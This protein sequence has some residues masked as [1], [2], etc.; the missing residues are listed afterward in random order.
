MHRIGVVALAVCCFAFM[1]TQAMAREYLK[2]DAAQTRGF[3]LGTVTEGGKIVWLAG[4][5]A[6][7]DE[8]G[9]SLL[10]DTAGQAR[11]IFRAMQRTLKRA[12]ADLKDLTVITVYLTDPRDL[13]SLIPVRREFF[14]DGNFPAST[15]IT[16][17][18][19]PQPGMVVE[20]S[21]IAVIGDK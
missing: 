12:G 2:L 3:S 5:T 18:N 21:G 1:A 20:I 7:R 16:V 4:H 10:G 14:P 11:A 9:K 19:L 15:S 8:D 17:A 13:D 6:L